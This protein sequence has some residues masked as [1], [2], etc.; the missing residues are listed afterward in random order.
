[1]IAAIIIF[2][3]MDN[4]FTSCE[5]LSGFFAFGGLVLLMFTLKTIVRDMSYGTIELF[6]NYNKIRKLYLYDKFI[7][8]IEMIFLFIILDTIVTLIST[9]MMTTSD[10][11]FTDFFKMFGDLL[12]I[13]LFYVS[14][15][16]IINLLT[17]KAVMVYTTAIVCIILLPTIFNILSI[18]PQI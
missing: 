8:L 10:L 5:L 9:F 18:V 17:G 1:S 2:L 15:L 7:F 13:I 12:I 14:L 3:N 11:E 4:L 16:N 6:L